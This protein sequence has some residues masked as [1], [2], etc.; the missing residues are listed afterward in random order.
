MGNMLPSGLPRTREFISKE[1]QGIQ[2]EIEDLEEML[3]IVAD[4][5]DDGDLSLIDLTIE[6]LEKQK[7]LLSKEL[8]S[9]HRVDGWNGS[10]SFEATESEH[11]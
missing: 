11:P 9:Y 4:S 8:Q 6:H 3:Q 2:S 5:D 7:L 1:I 10:T